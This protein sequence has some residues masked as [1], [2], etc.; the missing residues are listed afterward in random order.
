MKFTEEKLLKEF[1]ELQWDKNGFT[2]LFLPFSE[3]FNQ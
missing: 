1:N 3:I 2:T